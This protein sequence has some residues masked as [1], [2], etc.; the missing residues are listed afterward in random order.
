M[1]AGDYGQT[2]TY[3]NLKA[4]I[5]DYTQNSE[6]TF[7]S[8]INNFI[9]ATEEKIYFST[10]L[11]SAWSSENQDTASG[12]SDYTVGDGS[13]GVVE[14]FSVRLRK[15]AGAGGVADFGPASYL[16]RKDYDFLIEA[17]PGSTTVQSTGFPKYYAMS[18]VSNDGSDPTYNI[19]LG[20]APDAIY[21]MTTDYS[22]RVKTNSLVSDTSGTWLSTT[23]PD[24][25]MKG[26]IYEAYAFMKGEADLVQ[27]F[28][29]DFQ[30][31]L[32]LFKSYVEGRDPQDRYR[33]GRKR[34]AEI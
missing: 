24:L 25:L 5:Q 8:N 20:P 19:R 27:G 33:A 18:A 10:D 4:A 6:T 13:G 26:C 15:T 29:E 30:T 16:L 28:K 17:Y 11:P 1:T 34:A 2:P 21:A 23:F 31:E 3:A 32:I 9:T 22:A 14:V 12:Q 7:V